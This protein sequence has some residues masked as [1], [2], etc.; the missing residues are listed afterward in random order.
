MRKLTFALVALALLA[1]FAA[2]TSSEGGSGGGAGA[3][4]IAPDPYYGGPPD[5][6][7]A[8]D[9]AAEDPFLEEDYNPENDPGYQRAQEL[10]DQICSEHPE[11]GC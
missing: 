3:D 11:L 10:G 5:C 6:I 9:P 8:D 7:P 4:C 1:P 2:C